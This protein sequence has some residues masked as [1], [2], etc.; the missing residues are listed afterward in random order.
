M[1]RCYRSGALPNGSSSHFGG[2]NNWRKTLSSFD[3]DVVVVGAGLCGLSIAHLFNRKKLKVLVLES[4]ANPG[5]RVRSVRDGHTGE[6]LGDLGPTWVWPAY[7]PLLQRWLDTLA[8]STVAQFSGDNSLIETSPESEPQLDPVPSHMGAFRIDSGTSTLIDVL[9]ESIGQDSI[10]VSQAVQKIEPIDG[11][12]LV[13]TDAGAAPVRARRAVLAMPPRII[14]RDI[15]FSP[16]LPEEVNQAL[17]Q[18]PT[19]MASHAK[20][21][22]L[23]A[24]A[25]WREQSHG[26]R[27]FSRIGPIGEL[28]DHSGPD[29]SPAALTGFLAWPHELRRGA[30]EEIESAILAQLNRLFG[31]EAPRPLQIVIKDWAQDH[32]LSTAADLLENPGQRPLLPALLREPQLDG[33]VWLAGAEL[34]PESPGLIEGAFASAE[35]TA[36]KVVQSL[37]IEYTV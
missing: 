22:L 17:E 35:F 27:M 9:C 19:W 32:L 24:H 10:R 33:H 25:F 23:Y 7:Q 18:A 12:V 8:V 1:K 28:Q 34:A 20:I 11:G 16:A 36:N 6:A 3:C 4:R 13:H 15:R 26:G 5:G 37:G 21:V 31:D 2:F 29:G 14:R 30:D